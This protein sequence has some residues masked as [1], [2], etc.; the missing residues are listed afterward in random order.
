LFSATTKFDSDWAIVEYTAT[1]TTKK[2]ASFNQ[3]FCWICRYEGDKI[4]EVRMYE[5]SALVKSV[6]EENE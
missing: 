3:N 1:A 6:L 5:D 2:G 4:V